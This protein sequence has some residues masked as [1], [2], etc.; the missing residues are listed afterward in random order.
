[1]AHH[2]PEHASQAVSRGSVAALIPL[3]KHARLAQPLRQKRLMSAQNTTGADT[4]HRQL[5]GSF[6]F[7]TSPANPDVVLVPRSFCDRLAY[8]LW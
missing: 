5:W 3:E 4:V 8:A 7:P 1:M 2:F 6:S